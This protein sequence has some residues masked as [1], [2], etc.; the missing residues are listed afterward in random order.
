MGKTE[1]ENRRHQF[2]YLRTEMEYIM[3]RLQELKLRIELLGNTEEAKNAK[4][5][6]A[7]K[8]DELER[9][10]TLLRLLSRSES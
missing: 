9:Q 10:H 1:S 6:A 3:L 8:K 4:V 7:S 5:R 2:Q